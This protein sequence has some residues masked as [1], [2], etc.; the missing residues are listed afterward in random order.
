MLERM[1]IRR[2]MKLLPAD[3]ELLAAVHATTASP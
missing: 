1:M 3:Q 2:G